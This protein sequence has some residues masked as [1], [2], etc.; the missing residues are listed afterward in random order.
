MS[1]TREI[2]SFAIYP[3]IGVARVGNSPDGYF[4]GPELPWPYP[5]DPADYRDASG[6]INRQAARFRV[7]G[8]DAGGNVVE[9]IT[10]A[11]ATITWRVEVANKKAAWFAVGQKAS[12]Q[13]QSAFDVQ[14]SPVSSPLRNRAVQGAAR[15]SLSITP[16]PVTIV[17]KSVNDRGG[18]SRYDL[19]GQFFDRPVYLGEVRTDERGRLIF[20]GGHGVSASAGDCGAAE[21]AADNDGWHDDVSDG[22][23]DATVEYKG[24]TY[25]AEGAWVVVG[26]PDY[27]PGAQSIV[28]GYDLVFDVA[29]RC[30]PSLMPARP[31]FSEHI[32]PLLRRFTVM[33]WV[34]AGF[35]RCFGFGTLGDFTD[36][37]NIALLNG[38]SPASQLL[39]ATVFSLFRNPASASSLPSLLPPC[40]GDVWD[41]SGVTPY[42]RLSILPTQYR[43]LQQWANGC[44]VADGAPAPLPRW[45]GLSPPEQVRLI[46]RG[47]LDQTLGGPFAPGVEFT[48]PMRQALM[49]K[50]PFRIKRRIAPE[51]DLGPTLSS[52]TALAV[53]GPLDGSTPGDITRWMAVP[54]QADTA[55]CLSAYYPWVDDYLPTFWAPR[56]PN[57]VLTQKQYEVLMNSGRPPSERMLEL[58]LGR[59]LK[60]L[61]G[62]RY[63][64]KPAAGMVYPDAQAISKFIRDWGTVGIVEA[65]RGPGG[66]LPEELWVETGRGAVGGQPPNV[67]PIGIWRL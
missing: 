41:Q 66:P 19:S 18:N 4:L 46:D 6:C 55:S 9:E 49:Y 15:T 24:G 53:G 58:E 63:P 25:V 31:T 62:I 10:A 34:N 16:P 56:V 3:S 59:R 13:S 37:S 33:Q 42:S 28:T 50:A 2:K 5:R 40:Y 47:V 7:Y 1:D 26:P 12:G 29:T 43:W 45:E 64:L 44:F 51:P 21:D 60:W 20:L 48:W 38:P 54:W 14:G 27:A 61:R 52:T 36:P 30:D 22:P 17:G 32:Y 65:R 67:Q 39:R 57:D 11:E 8:L 23:V 35:A